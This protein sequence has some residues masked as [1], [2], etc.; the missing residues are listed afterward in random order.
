MAANE[1]QWLPNEPRGL[2]AVGAWAWGRDYV[3]LVHCWTS[4]GKRRFGSLPKGPTLAATG[5]HIFPATVLADAQW[6]RSEG[7]WRFSISAF[8]KWFLTFFKMFE[9]PPFVC[10]KYFDGESSPQINAL[11]PLGLQ[12]PIK[13]RPSR[14]KG[15]YNR[16]TTPPHTEKPLNRGPNQRTP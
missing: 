5:E 9:N 16:Y 1:R 12:C 8:C 4:G 6:G 10:L 3:A 14:F 13:C 15:G 7:L 11:G 2:L